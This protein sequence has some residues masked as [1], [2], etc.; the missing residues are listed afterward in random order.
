MTAFDIEKFT[1]GWIMGD[2]HPAIIRTKDAEVAIKRYTAGQSEPAHVHKI[3]REITV[4]IDGMVSMNGR[5][6]TKD[7]AI[8][9]EPG[10][11][12]DFLALTDAVTCVIK[13]PSVIGDKYFV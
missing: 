9:I 4:I 10:D 3:A 8:C 6:Y 5:T 11:V 13:T 12:T 2:F 7:T 1:G